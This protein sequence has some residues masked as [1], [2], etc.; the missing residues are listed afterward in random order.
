MV[1]LGSKSSESWGEMEPI[2]HIGTVG[3]AIST[4][5]D[6]RKRLFV[7]M[8]IFHS[9]GTVMIEHRN[10]ALNRQMDRSR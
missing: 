3:K 9:Q 2:S 4:Q 6:C 5:Q 1:D 8:Y 10:S 7:L